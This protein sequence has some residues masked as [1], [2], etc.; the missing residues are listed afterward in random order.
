MKTLCSHKPLP[1]KPDDSPTVGNIFR[2][3]GPSFRDTHRLH[4]RQHKVMY[5]IE[6]CRR[7]EFGTHWEICDNC[8]HLE[9]GYNSCRNRHCPGCNNIARRRWVAA[10]IDELLP[11]SYHH[12]VFTL[13]DI[14][15]PLC[16]FNR[17]VMY[18]LLFESASQTLLEFGENP[19]RLGARIG[20][21]GILHTWGGKLWLHP[22]IHFIVT[23]GGVN[24]R[25][26]WVEPKYHASFL[27]PVRAL[28][29]VFRAKFLSG[30]IAAHGK[31]LLNLPGDLA[32]FETPDVF[33]QWLFH[34]VPRDWV[35]YSKPPFSGP[36][37]VVKYIGRYTHSA[38]I[39][40][41]RI[42]C[43]END[44]VTF[45]FKNTRKKC[46]WETTTLPAMEFINRF[47]THV[48]PKHFHRI[49]YYGF[50]ANGKAGKLISSIRQ[51]LNDRVEQSAET[52]SPI[53]HTCQCPAC[54]N[55]TMMTIL[56]LDGFGNVVKDA[57][58]ETEAA[59]G[60][61]AAESP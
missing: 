12:C 3:F 52:E 48:L 55:G 24:T 28:S 39:S 18:D 9:K 47:L 40:N 46:R 50:L 42:I 13:P 6:H 53:D 8:G 2:E 7:G 51:A 19:K 15:N 54:G 37:E 31:G 38:A 11:V 21:Y 16:R 60:I 1:D 56:V 20:F 61:K 45:W 29:N 57:G 23:A 59:L 35:V 17:R 14:F 5:D 36:A 34:T 44:M 58:S 10:R 32:R 27:F 41:N 4:P 25:G 33:R 49:R 43:V 30:L 22:H 26:Q